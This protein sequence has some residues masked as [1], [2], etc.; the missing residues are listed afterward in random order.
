MW[1]PGE[2]GAQPGAR[3]CECLQ[4]G[5]LVVNK[6]YRVQIVFTMINGLTKNEIK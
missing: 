3:V 6:Y 4:F 5:S 1:P 2:A